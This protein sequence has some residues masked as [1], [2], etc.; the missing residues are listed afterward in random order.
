MKMNDLVSEAERKE[1]VRWFKEPMTTRF[2]C[3]RVHTLRVHEN[4]M[5]HLLGRENERLSGAMAADDLPD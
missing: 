1:L 3:I 5:V 2:D 4:D